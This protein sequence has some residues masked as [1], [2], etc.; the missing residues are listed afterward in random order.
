[1]ATGDIHI[2]TVP[3][4]SS[5]TPFTRPNE[6]GTVTTYTEKSIA[7]DTILLSQFI[8]E[9]QAAAGGGSELLQILDGG[10]RL[11]LVLKET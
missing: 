9:Q 8:N 10:N 11:V 5:V 3:A 4:V 1:M 7:A 6:Y 2:T